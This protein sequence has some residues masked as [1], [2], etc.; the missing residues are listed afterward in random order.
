[1]LG[2]MADSASAAGSHCTTLY[3][4]QK[5]GS[6]TDTIRERKKRR[7]Q[8]RKEAMEESAEIKLLQAKKRRLQKRAAG[9]SKE[10]MMCMWTLWEES[11]AKKNANLKEK[12][13]KGGA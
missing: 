2:E 7:T 12:A 9:M 4:L 5:N 13:K 10:Q 6:I 11:D 3:M 8:K 1:M